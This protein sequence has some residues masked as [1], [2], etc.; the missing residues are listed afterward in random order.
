M[1]AKFNERIDVTTSHAGRNFQAQC[2]DALRGT[3]V[4]RVCRFLERY[5]LSPTDG[6]DVVPS[7]AIGAIALRRS[8]RPRGERATRR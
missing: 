8:G 3:L 1:I 6:E 4:E 7:A 5:P 2:S